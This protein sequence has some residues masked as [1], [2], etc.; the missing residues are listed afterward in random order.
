MIRY[1]KVGELHEVD[2]DSA[3]K[4]YLK[5]YYTCPRC[6]LSNPKIEN[7]LREP[8]VKHHNIRTYYKWHLG[9]FRTT[10]IIAAENWCE[11]C[12]SRWSESQKI[13]GEFTWRPIGKCIKYWIIMLIAICIAI[14][15]LTWCIHIS[16]IPTVEQE[17]TSGQFA[18][19][20]IPALVSMAVIIYAIVKIASI[21]CKKNRDE[22]RS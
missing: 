11:K 1:I 3:A 9:L 20:L 17:V 21:T 2:L 14:P 6:G 7:A 15:T 12:N 13:K 19:V 18:C 5:T 8:V 10:H 4:T 22:K 16:G